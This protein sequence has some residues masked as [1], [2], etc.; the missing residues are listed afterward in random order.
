MVVG[1]VRCPLKVYVLTIMIK[2]LIMHD[3]VKVA[4]YQSN[5]TFNSI[6]PN[7]NKTSKKNPITISQEPSTTAKGIITCLVDST[8]RYKIW[9]LSINHLLN[10]FYSY[11]HSKCPGERAIV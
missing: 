2:L 8:K 6:D 7:Y 5:T 9:R 1:K 11:A 4:I 10:L 3:R